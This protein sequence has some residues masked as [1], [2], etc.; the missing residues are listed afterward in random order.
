MPTKGKM[1]VS[2]SA[3]MQTMTLEPVTG[4]QIVKDCE[5]QEWAMEAADGHH[6]PTANRPDAAEQAV[7]LYG[8]HKIASAGNTLAAEVNEAEKRAQDLVYK[9]FKAFTGATDLARQAC[10]RVQADMEISLVAAATKRITTR[11][12]LGMF[13]IREAIKRALRRPESMRYI[14]IGHVIAIAAE[15][16]GVLHTYAPAM[17]G[18]FLEATRVSGLLA[19]VTVLGIGDGFALAL[20]QLCSRRW[21][22]R[23]IGGAAAVAY[24]VVLGAWACLLSFYRIALQGSDIP[25]IDAMNML[26]TLP[27]TRAFDSLESTVLIGITIASALTASAAVFVARDPIPNYHRTAMTAEDARSEETEQKKAYHERIGDATAEVTDAIFE[28]YETAIEACGELREIISH[29]RGLN[30]EA[31]EFGHTLNAGQRE[32]SNEYRRMVGQVL[33]RDIESFNGEFDAGE[34]PDL[35]PLVER[36]NE[37][38]K[39]LNEAARD[40]RLGKDRDAA[41]LAVDRVHTEFVN[42]AR[43]FFT[44]CEALARGRL[45]RGQYDE[46]MVPPDGSETPTGGPQIAYQRD[47]AEPKPEAA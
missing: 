16:G 7:I 17:P 39:A 43:A 6:I 22:R 15:T 4:A 40:D 21:W 2:L 33:G 20:R 23:L 32:A 31:Q 24:P 36:L 29:I 27:F 34:L 28:E 42:D 11:I 3:N 25:G 45:V 12:E 8:R 41:V 35:T 37:I 5:L 44:R 9:A 13:K 19:T 18:G 26:Q 47:D 30:V 38:E 46:D 14:V 1:G 10:E